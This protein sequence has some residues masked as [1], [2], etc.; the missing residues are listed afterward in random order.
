MP[1]DLGPLTSR[2]K[3]IR[4]CFALHG[5]DAGPDPAVTCHVGVYRLGDGS[6]VDVAPLVNQG[7]RW[8]RL[9]RSTAR[10]T[11][12]AEGRW[13]STLGSTNRIEGPQPQLGACGEGRIRFEGQ[14]GDRTTL[15]TRD[16]I[17]IGQPEPVSIAD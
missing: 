13:V 6:W 4:R 15:D 12:D 3:A 2:S 7:L 9:D 1:V 11:H 16:A 14:F 10:M 8:R 5:P 17:F